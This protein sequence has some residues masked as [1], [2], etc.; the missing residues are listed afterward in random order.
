[1]K[2]FEFDN[3]DNKIDTKEGGGM[4]YMTTFVAFHENLLKVI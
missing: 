3:I 1:M 2:Y 4:I